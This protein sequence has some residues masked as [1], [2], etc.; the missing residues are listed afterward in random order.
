MANHLEDGCTPKADT[1]KPKLKRHTKSG[2][3]ILYYCEDFKCI[4]NP[5]QSNLDCY[6]A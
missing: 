5:I 2:Y 4:M 1:L 3:S 6:S